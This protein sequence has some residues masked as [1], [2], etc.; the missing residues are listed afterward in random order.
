MKRQQP[1]I[2]INRTAYLVDVDQEQFIQVD[3]PGNRIC[4]CVLQRTEHGYC[5]RLNQK[6]NKVY[7]GPESQASCDVAIFHLPPITRIDP[8][9]LAKKYNKPIAYFMQMEYDKNW[10]SE[11]GVI[12]K[13]K[14]LV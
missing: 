13:L 14:N 10:L 9:G 3:Q 6:T 11:E 7:F 8:I 5:L 4:F 1:L 2:T 12:S